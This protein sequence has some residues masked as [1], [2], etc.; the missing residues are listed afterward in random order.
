MPLRP[1]QIHPEEHLGPVGG[2]GAAGAGADRQDRGA[3]VVLAREQQLRALPIEVPLEGIALAVALGGELGIAGF[4]DELAQGLEFVR[5][6]LEAGPQLDL[7]AQPVCLAQDLLGGPL[8]VPESG[9]AGQAFELAEAP[10]SFG[11]IKDAPRSPGSARPGRGRRRRPSVSDLE[12]VEQDR[13]ELDESESR[14]APG[15]DGVHAGTVAVVGAH[16]A[17]AIAVERRGVAAT[18]AVALA[19]DQIDEG[20]FLGLLHDSLFPQSDGH[21][22][23]LGRRS[24]VDVGNGAGGCREYRWPNRLRQEGNVVERPASCAIQGQSVR[25]LGRSVNFRGVRDR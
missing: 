8:V 16:A 10:L 20:R 12:I 1:A 22:D 7:G 25:N 13:T 19:G 17:V 24:L 9:R 15:D 3:V 14:L 5:A 6:C 4:L 21:T 23:P 18:P 11:E 2:F